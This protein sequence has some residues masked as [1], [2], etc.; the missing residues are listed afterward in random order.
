GGVE[1]EADGRVG[2]QSAAPFAAAGQKKAR[3]AVGERRFANAA[4]ARQQPGMG[5]PAG[6]STLEQR[7][8]GALLPKK[9]RIPLRLHRS[10]HKQ[11]AERG[12]DLRP[13]GV[14]IAT[15]ID[16]DAA[17]RVAR[18]NGEESPAQRLMKAAI[19]LLIAVFPPPP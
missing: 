9:L 3:E 17:L 2:K 10:D 12:A 13:C 1:R 11:A 8:L 15:G 14:F 19:H 16:D 6:S 5:K 18:G 7:M 4:R